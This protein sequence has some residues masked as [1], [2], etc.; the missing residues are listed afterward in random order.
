MPPVRFEPT[1]SVL[2]PVKTVRAL[3]R[4]ATAI[5]LPINEE[6]SAHRSTCVP[7][8]ARLHVIV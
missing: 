6:I 7:V 3:G 4:A 8:S 1:V 2:E 5:G